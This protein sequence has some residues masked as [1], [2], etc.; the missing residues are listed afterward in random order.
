MKITDLKCTTIGTNPVIR[1]TTDEGI[2]GLG[3]VEHAKGYIKPHVMFY[4]DLIVGEDPRNVERVMLKIRRMGAFKPW[5]SA[6]SGIEMALWDIAGKAAGLPIYRLLG[7]K[8]RD[9]VR[10]YNGA[11]RF[12]MNGQSPQDYADNMA[13]MKAS[14]EKFSIIKQGIAFHSQMAREIPGFFYGD[15]QPGRRH[16]NRG[17]L[18]ERGLKHVIECVE[19][20]KD[21]LGD[22][23]GLALDCG[24]G[25]TVPD[26]IRLA[27]ALE[28]LNIMWLEDMITGDYTPYVL[29]ELYRDVTMS[30]S[31][32]IHTGE[33][34]YLRQNFKQLIETRAVNVV[35]PDPCDVGGLAE[36]KWIAEY[37]DLHGILMAPHGT[38]D[39]LIGMAGLVQLAATLPDNY[40][41]FEYPIG[42]PDWWHDI[43]EGLP[44]QIVKDGFIDVWDRPGLGIDFKV[45]AAQKYLPAGDEDFFD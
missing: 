26:A 22:E 39:G 15:V 24:P 23:V 10:V 28:P 41:A 36:L 43:V 27:K 37:A 35:G 3:A 8:V 45:D 31:T 14:K 34:I 33:Q 44:D 6:V 38:G 13:K 16:P 30:T 4:K 18:T 5:G 40:I 7:G 21:V 19:A 42:D 9:R 32:P 11:V 17:L 25:W 12:P 20:M 29:A 1:I 2:S